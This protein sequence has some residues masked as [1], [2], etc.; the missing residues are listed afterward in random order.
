MAFVVDCDK[1]G[2]VYSYMRLLVDQYFVADFLIAVYTSKTDEIESAVPGSHGIGG[3]RSLVHRC[4]AGTVGV[5]AGDRHFSTAVAIITYVPVTY[6]LTEYVSQCCYN[7]ME[8]GKAV[9]YYYYYY[10]YVLFTNE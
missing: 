4:T 9:I 3:T 8:K 5:G 7:V 2:R 10:Y 6:I 1:V